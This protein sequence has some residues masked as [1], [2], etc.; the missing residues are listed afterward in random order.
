MASFTSIGWCLAATLGMIALTDAAFAQTKVSGTVVSVAP[1]GEAIAFEEL[2][3]AGKVVRH[4]LALAPDA[5]VV[6]VTRHAE[7]GEFVAQPANP[8]DLRAG[9]FVTVTVDG[10]VLDLPPRATTTDTSGMASPPLDA[11]GIVGR[12]DTRGAGIART[13]EIVRPR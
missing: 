6:Q 5:R 8:R 9:D 2:G 10:G 4:T 3:V 12:Y 13:V 11:R 7:H 1:D